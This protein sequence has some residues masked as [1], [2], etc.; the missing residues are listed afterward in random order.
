MAQTT[1]KE[2]IKQSPAFTN[3]TDLAAERLGGKVLYATD[4]FFAEKENLIKPTRGVFITDKYTDRGK[5]M[6]GWESR[7]KRTPGHDWAIIQL[8]TSGIIKG[9]DIDT[10]FF[11]G[12]HPP[13][14]SIE[15]VNLTGK[16]LPTNWE[17][18]EWKEILPKSH[19]DAGSQNFFE[20]SDTNIYTHIRLHIYPDGGV[21][22]LR[23]YGN[24]FKQWETISTND[25]LDLAAAINGGKAIACNDM[26]FSSMNNLLMP[27]RGVNMGDGWETK[28]N[29]TPNNR[30]WVIIK[31]AHKGIAQKIIVDTNHFKGNYPD[32]CSLEYCVSNNDD[33][34]INNT[35]KWESL[36][37]QQKL[38]ASAEHCFE[39]EINNHTA[40]THIRLNIFPDGG[41][42]RLRI[43][44][45]II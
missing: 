16:E 36:L 31:L 39:K 10:N 45:K 3:L 41:I 4:D 28:R 8:A 15:A 37:P 23:V 33:A 26:F 12:N 1:V 6:D 29:R 14:A 34:V 30:D 27:N 25:T 32:S 18:I 44:G 5:W 35:I 42:S 9:F 40:I 43:F 21:A 17:E 19:L 2:I 22:R 38:K 7:R 24:V 13:H 20:C 11:L